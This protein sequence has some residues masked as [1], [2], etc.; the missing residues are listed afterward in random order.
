MFRQMCFPFQLIAVALP[1]IVKRGTA[2]PCAIAAAMSISTC[3]AAN[4]EPTA[5]QLGFFEAK[6]R[7]LLVENCYTCHS[8]DTNAQGGLR[9]DDRN[10]LLAGGNRGAAV[11]P[12]KPEESILLQA[13][14]HTDKRLKMPPGKQLSPEQIADLTLW[15][16]DGAAWPH[17]PLEVNL[18]ER[19][20]DYDRLRREHWAWQPLKAAEPPSAQPTAWP[21]DAVDHFILAKLNAEGL[22]PVADA[23]RV[24]LIRRVTFD[25]TGLP[26]TIEEIDAFLADES[27]DAYERVVDRLLASPAYGER[28]GRHWLD[29]AR[30]GESTGSSRNIPLPHAWRYRDYVI[31]SFNADK[32]Y[33]QFI[34]EQIAGDLLPAESEEQRREHLIAT[35]FLALGVKDVNQ[36]FKVRFIMDNVDEQIDTVSRSVLALTA[37]CA[38]CHDHKFDPIPAR[39]YYA[40]AG[41]FRSSELCAGVRSKMGG[42]GLDYYN[43]QA[44]VRLG[45]EAKAAPPEKLAKAKQKL[46]KAQKEWNAIRGTPE[47][48]SKGPDGRPKQRRFRVAFDQAQEEYLELTDPTLQG[49]AAVGVR[50]SNEIADTEYRIRGEAEAL[51]PAVPRGYLSLLTVPNAAPIPANQSGRLELAQWLTSPDNS[52]AS[53]VIVNRV[54]RHLFGRGIVSS[55]DNFGTTGDIPSHPELLDHLAARFVE[56][57]WSIKKFVRTLVL[58]RTYQL[59]S[60]ASPAN[61]AIDP[62]NRYL[63]RHAPRRL[64]AEELRDALLAASGQLRSD[65][66]EGSPVTQLKVMELQNNSRPARGIEEAASESHHR[67]VYLPLVR[68]LTPTSLQVFDFAEQGMVSGNRDVTT[69]ATQALYML[70]DPFIRRHSLNLSKRLLNAESTDEAAQVNEAYRLLLGREATAAETA[71]AIEFLA[72]YETALNASEAVDKQLVAAEAQPEAAAGAV[73]TNGASGTTTPSGAKDN[74]EPPPDPDQIVYSD[75]PVKEESLG[76]IDART[77]AWMSFCQALFGSVECRYVK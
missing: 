8:A 18:N 3:I 21:R 72:A 34:R 70:N 14:N 15:I 41:I 25:L 36:R 7:P 75:A 38:R 37:S 5:E 48:V 71:R 31:D 32:P 62:A 59:D 28:W 66:P 19:N 42:G 76:P 27:P 50:D 10:G 20:A 64:D 77:A 23:D 60:A 11:V 47:G 16:N 26:P 67:S 55:V 30:Y 52:L 46:D 2:I 17:V 40:L 65:R 6:I 45:G 49:D 1:M 24:T 12:G 54:W 22:E 51:G 35:G 74:N 44:L 13:V 4:V 73:A 69:V 61:L 39:D 56:E 29:V 33:D 57:G 43:P 63:W 9:V 53:R 58:T 68:S